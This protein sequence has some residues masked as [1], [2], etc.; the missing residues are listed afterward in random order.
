[1]TDTD[2][3]Y[4]LEVYAEGNAVAGPWWSEERRYTLQRARVVA[5]EIIKER[6]GTV[7]VDIV[8]AA[9][10]ELVERIVP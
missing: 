6:N 5:R 3:E 1:M 4:R 8:D 9:T 7:T 10:G 2:K